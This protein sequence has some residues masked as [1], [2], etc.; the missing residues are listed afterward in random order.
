MTPA[1]ILIVD[2]EPHTVILIKFCLRPLQ[3][4]LFTAT[5]GAA[6]LALMQNQPIDLVL[7]DV[8]MKGVDGLTALR[9]MKSEPA[10]REIPVILMTA[11]GEAG[12]AEEGR[13]LGVRAFFSKPFSSVAVRAKIQELLK[14]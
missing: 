6:A 3:A 14:S 10:L 9:L 2:D 7:L 5:D 8:Q 13:A 11:G 1:N 12:I 4:N